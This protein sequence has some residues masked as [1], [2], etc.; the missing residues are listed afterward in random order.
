MD[1][2]GLIGKNIDYSFSRGYFNQKFKDESIN[3]DY[4]NFDLSEISEFNSVLTEQNL[5]GLNVTI[6][7]KSAIIPFLDNVDAEAK[8]IGA[9]NTIKFRYGKLIG[10]NT[11]VYGF[12]RSII[13]LLKDHH[14]KALV[15]G[16]GGASKAVCYGL[17]QL[18][19]D[20]KIVSRSPSGSNQIA[21]DAVYKGLLNDYT[22]IIN[23]TP[24]GTYPNIS[25]A[26]SIPYTHLTAKH[27]L[28]DLVYNPEET[29]F[30]KKGIAQDAQTV[31]GYQM[32]VLQAEKAWAIWNA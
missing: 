19:I 30:M 32:L 10:F 16:T 29:A 18:K 8:A 1:K 24:I 9:V 5:K 22:I 23:C 21:Y 25:E 27:L 7:Y 13:P 31:N 11:D 4:V 2:Y 28:Y 26:P 15:L 12:K 20:F 6:P 17:K 14:K 3:A